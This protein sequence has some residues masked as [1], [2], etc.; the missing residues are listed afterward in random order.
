MANIT[1]SIPQIHCISCEALIRLSLKN[2]LGIRTSSV[3]L[4]SKTATV[5]FD[6]QII[7]KEKIQQQIQKDTGYIVS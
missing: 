2:L 1:F 4:S 6:D 3:D 5:E 7:T